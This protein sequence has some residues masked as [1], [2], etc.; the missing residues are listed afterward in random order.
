MTARALRFARGDDAPLPGMEEKSRAA[1]AGHGSR[2]LPSL[3]DEL[4]SLRGATVSLMRSFDAAA[5]DRAGEASG[6]RFTVRALAW[7]TV[8]HAIHH[9]VILRDRYLGRKAGR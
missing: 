9:R 5:P 7:R 6:F 3:L 2:P 4:E 8:G 1:G